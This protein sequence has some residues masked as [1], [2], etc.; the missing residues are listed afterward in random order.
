[1]IYGAGKFIAA[2]ST[3]NTATSLAYSD[4]GS[5]W[6]AVDIGLQYID[7]LATD[8]AQSLVVVDGSESNSGTDRHIYSTVNGTVYTDRLS[9]T[10]DV[11]S[12]VLATGAGF[13]QVCANPNTFVHTS[14]DGVTWDG[15]TR[16]LVK[17]SGRLFV[18]WAGDNAPRIAFAPTANGYY[19]SRLWV[20][21]S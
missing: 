18:L 8:D 17:L 1:V 16:S 4:D 15:T 14:H 2:G 6:T 19:R 21:P 12:V 10:G 7:S 9:Y 11:T 5:S 13:A 20:V 3:G